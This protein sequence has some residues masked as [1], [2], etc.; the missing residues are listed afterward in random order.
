M[1]FR[2]E[3]VA[4]YVEQVNAGYGRELARDLGLGPAETAVRLETRFWFN[5]SLRSKYAF[6]PGLLAVILL[7]MPAT[8][9][10][11]AVVRERE[12]GSIAN[13]YATPATRVEFVLAKQLPYA[14]LSL[15]SFVSLSALVVAA[16][17]VPLRG[18]F[19]GLALGAVPYVLAGTALG[20]VVSSFTRTQAASALVTVLIAMIPSFQYSGL[21]SPVSAMR[22]AAHVFARLFPATYYLSISVG[23]FTKGLGPSDLLGDYLVLALMALAFSA[24]SVALLRKQER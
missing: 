14:A 20:M 19:A 10:A 4:R 1:P 5:Q 7:L 16:F 9:T 23:A 3:T 22:G 24:A 15:A 13:F 18:S 11:V 21:L 2:A 8:L 12:L 6:V 17:Q